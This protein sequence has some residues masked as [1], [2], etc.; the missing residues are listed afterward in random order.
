MTLARGR[1]SRQSHSS[2][3]RRVN[4]STRRKPCAVVNSFISGTRRRPSAS[5]NCKPLAASP[6]RAFRGAISGNSSAQRS[7]KSP[8]NCSTRSRSGKTTPSGSSLTQ[9]CGRFGPV[10]IRLPAP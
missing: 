1:R 8:E 7:M 4:S 10:R 3:N 2:P 5:G 6:S 9:L